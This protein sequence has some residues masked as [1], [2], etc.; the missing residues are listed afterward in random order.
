MLEA[1]TAQAGCHDV[2]DGQEHD[3]GGQA[4]LE[5]RRPQ[6]R[7]RIFGTAQPDRSGTPAGRSI[8]WSGDAATLRGQ[9]ALRQRLL[10]V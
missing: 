7:V 5:E 9:D 10:G 6:S 1:M 3:D 8:A 4:R 2:L